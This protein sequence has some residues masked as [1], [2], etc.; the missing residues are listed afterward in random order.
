MRETALTDVFEDVDDEERRHQVVD[1]L[2]VAAGRVSDG[3]DKQDPLENLPH[4]KTQSQNTF[5]RKKCM[6]QVVSIYNMNKDVN[7]CYALNNTD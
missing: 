2:H 3:P 1:A 7:K 5:S 4:M 6:T